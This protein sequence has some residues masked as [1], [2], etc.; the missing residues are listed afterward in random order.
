[1]P[2]TYGLSDIFF[3]DSENGWAVGHG[4]SGIAPGGSNPILMHT[5]NGGEDWEGVDIMVGHSLR[6]VFF[7]DIDNGWVRGAGGSILH[8]AK[9]SNR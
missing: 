5:S 4:V 1:L 8:I 9:S 6:S 3:I 2:Y 7:T